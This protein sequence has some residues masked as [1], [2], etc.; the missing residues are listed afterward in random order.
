MI[1]GTTLDAAFVDA[2]EAGTKVS[3]VLQ[4]AAYVCMSRVKELLIV[5]VLQ[6]FSTYL[7]SRGPPPGPERMIRKLEAANPA[8]DALEEWALTGDEEALEADK[9]K[10][11]AASLCILLSTRSFRL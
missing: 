5:C 3:L 10:K 8:E 9:E 11:N 6:P 4:T 2:Q 7:F 1:Q